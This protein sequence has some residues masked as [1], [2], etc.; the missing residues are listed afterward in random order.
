[1]AG[2]TPANPAALAIVLEALLETL[3]LTALV[4]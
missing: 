3:A 4:R 1:M 2:G